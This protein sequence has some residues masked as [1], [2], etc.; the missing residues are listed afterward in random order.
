MKIC[1]IYTEYEENMDSPN[2]GNPSIFETK[3]I[4]S[5][6]HNYETPNFNK[7]IHKFNYI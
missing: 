4:D 5:I 2:Y 7:I 6:N 1:G 3:T